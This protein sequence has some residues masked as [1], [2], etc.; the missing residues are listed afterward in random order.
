MCLGGIVLLQTSLV[1]ALSWPQMK[2]S[3]ESTLQAINKSNP[4]LLSLLR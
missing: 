3:D 1:L 2:L 4:K